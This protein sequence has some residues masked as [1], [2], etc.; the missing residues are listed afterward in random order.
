MRDVLLLDVKGRITQKDFAL[1][2]G[3]EIKGAE[4]RICFQGKRGYIQK[5][6][7]AESVKT[8]QVLAVIAKG[9]MK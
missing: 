9:I 5:K 6:R 8:R 1:C 4:L 7:N 3:L 2:I